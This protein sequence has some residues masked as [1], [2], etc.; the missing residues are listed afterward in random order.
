MY[1]FLAGLCQTIPDVAQEL[2]KKISPFILNN[3]DERDPV[4]CPAVWESVLSLVNFVTVWLYLLIHIFNR[5]MLYFLLVMQSNL[6]MWSPLLSSHLYLKVT[7]SSS[8]IENF[9]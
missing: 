2:S 3:I 7:S 4:I 1:T 9:M 6:P 5:L 8:V